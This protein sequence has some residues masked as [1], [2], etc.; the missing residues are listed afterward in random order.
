MSADDRG[1][2]YK[3]WRFE[4]NPFYSP[5]HN[6]YPTQT[7]GDYKGD[8]KYRHIGER[9]RTEQ[10]PQPIRTRVKC[11]EREIGKNQI[12]EPLYVTIS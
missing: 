8:E 2:M 6:F 12:S 7:N 3:V 9:E 10:A 11:F 4:T 5:S 1:Y